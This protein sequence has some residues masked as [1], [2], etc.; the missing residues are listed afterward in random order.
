MVSGRVREERNRKAWRSLQSNPALSLYASKECIK[1]TLQDH[2]IAIWHHRYSRFGMRHGIVQFAY[3]YYG[4]GGTYG[5]IL[6]VRSA[7]S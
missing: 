3:E 5:L 7:K 6:E 1:L 2:A 4:I